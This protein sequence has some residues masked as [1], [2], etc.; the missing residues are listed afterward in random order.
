MFT[1]LHGI[2]N[3]HIVQPYNVPFE[4]SIG[5]LASSIFSCE[6]YIEFS[7]FV[8]H[9]DLDSYGRIT[10]NQGYHFMV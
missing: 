6:H 1:P 10:S 2:A 9:L 7:L 3:L 5:N 8:I 4:A